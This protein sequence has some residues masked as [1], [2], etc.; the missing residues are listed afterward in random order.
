[1][2]RWLWFHN[3]PSPPPA[4]FSKLTR[5]QVVARPQYE[6]PDFDGFDGII[7]PMHADQRHLSGLSSR[8][9]R[10]VDDGGA[11]L[12]N[13]HVAHPFLP[14]LER[15][16]PVVNR[17]LEGLTL[18]RELD[19]PLF[20]GV[21]VETLTFNKG[22]A[23]FYGRGGNPAP[24]EATVIHTV[25]RERLPVDWVLR[26]PSGGRLFVHS[27]NTIVASLRRAG[28]L[29]RFLCQLGRRP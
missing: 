26:R 4:A 8:L 2:V 1:M 24:P 21:P 23:G 12:V 22:V 5:V 11:I 6:S 27:G 16:V 13:G 25:G 9:D 28:I 29:E 14:E 7:V 10:F 18:H 3:T 20:A 19:H 17:D 15:F